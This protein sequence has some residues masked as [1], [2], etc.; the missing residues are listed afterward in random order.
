MTK[1]SIFKIH[2]AFLNSNSKEV[3]SFDNVFKEDNQWKI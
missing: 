2:K 1:F 3:I